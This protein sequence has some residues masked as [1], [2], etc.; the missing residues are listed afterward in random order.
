MN[1]KYK[2]NFT[3]IIINII[4]FICI[5]VA[6]PAQAATNPTLT[7]NNPTLDNILYPNSHTPQA[8]PNFKYL[9]QP[10][11]MLRDAATDGNSHPGLYMYPD[12]QWTDSEAQAN[13][14][15]GKN[16]F[17]VNTE[18][19]TNGNKTDFQYLI[20]SNGKNLQ[21]TNTY[22]AYVSTPLAFLEAV[23]DLQNPDYGNRVSHI[24]KVVIKQ[25]LDFYDTSNIDGSFGFANGSTFSYNYAR[26]FKFTIDGQGHTINFSS[27]CIALATPGG[28]YKEDWNLKNLHTYGSTFWGPVAGNSGVA[29]NAEEADKG[30]SDATI[31][32][33]GGFTRITYD[34]FSYLGAQVHNSGSGSSNTEIVIKNRVDMSS[35]DRYK[36][37][38]IEYQCD[39]NGNQQIFEASKIIFDKNSVFTGYTYDGI[40]IALNNAGLSDYHKSNSIKLE[41]GAKVY[42]FPHGDGSAET[43]GNSRGMPYAITSF[44]DKSKMDLYGDAELN[45]ISN[46]AP[47]KGQYYNGTNTLRHNLELAGGLYVSGQFELNYHK[48]STG[49]PTIRVQSNDQS[50]MDYVHPENNVMDQNGNLT[51]PATNNAAVGDSNVDW[52]AYGDD[53]DFS[54]DDYGKYVSC[55]STS[56]GSAGT[57]GSTTTTGATLNSNPIIYLGNSSKYQ[58]T[59]TI[60]NGTFDVQTNNLHNFGT[61]SPN[62]TWVPSNG[63]VMYIGGGMN[64]NI[65]KDGIFRLHNTGDKQTGNGMNL[66]QAAQGLDLN[67]SN[68]KEVTLDLGPNDNSASNIVYIE[69]GDSN[70]PG[71]DVNVNNSTFSAT[72]NASVVSGPSG[73]LGSDDKD[74]QL[75]NIPIQKMKIPFSYWAIPG[76]LFQDGTNAIFAKQA[77]QGLEE[78]NGGLDSMNGK[79]FHSINF[80]KLDSPVID[81]QTHEIV[82]HKNREVHLTGSVTH[83]DDDTS[84]DPDPP[85]IR[86]TLQR[87]DQTY[88]LGTATNAS[89]AYGIQK[90]TKK[91]LPVTPDILGVNDN[92]QQNGLIAANGE[93]KIVESAPLYLSPDKKEVQITPVNSTTQKYTTY[94]YDINLQK[95]LDDLP[96]DS[97]IGD[98]SSRDK[99]NVSAV[100]NF[101]QTPE[102]PINIVNLILKTDKNVTQYLTG[103]DVKVPISY[104]DGN[105]SA[106]ELTLDGTVNDAGKDHKITS[107]NLAMQHNADQSDSQTN[108]SISGI[109]N[110][111]D[112]ADTTHKI[113]FSGQDDLTPSNR[114][115]LLGNPDLTYEYQVLPYPKYSGISS[116]PISDSQPASTVKAGHQTLITKFTPVGH[117]DMRK[118]RLQL[119]TITNGGQTS[120]QSIKV[121]ASYPNSDPGADSSNKKIS[122]TITLPINSDNLY[123]LSGKD[124][125]F[126]G[127]M[128]PADTTFTIKQNVD[129]KGTSNQDYFQADSGILSAILPDGTTKQ[130]AKTPAVKDLITEPDIKLIAPNKL[131][132]SAFTKVNRK[133]VY[134]DAVDEYVQLLN[135]AD[136]DMNDVNVYAQYQGDKNIA[137]RLYYQTNS[138]TSMNLSNPALI[139]QGSLSQ[140]STKLL[141]INPKSGDSNGLFLDL[142]KND[143]SEGKYDGALTWS[144]V[145]SLN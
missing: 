68:P 45:I 109:T 23:Y 74:V 43:A 21:S 66:L 112:T 35:V 144:A 5:G 72:G 118:V 71:G 57:D 79:E 7:T 129:V 115:P 136:Y 40:G 128:I 38:G 84:F 41:D 94:K 117:H 83:Y 73:N 54:T 31:E 104:F 1:I 98:I 61:A 51:I 90:G 105:A 67:I 17:T 88:D 127:D 10:S 70:N 141:N 33:G 25:D 119:G 69:G 89:Q 120:D 3:V 121:T 143:L 91:V 19:Q 133:A 50:T 138:S 116:F 80:G 140:K 2:L 131:N 22:T 24:S 107:S 6:R 12:F 96:K 9:T 48:D 63:Y 85:M 49:S 32:T 122:Q 99:L 26:H 44:G 97:P 39:S 47:A 55:L 36:Y 92:Q 100:T 62:S 15:D 102:Q 132:F 13:A 78:L 87:N 37:K 77:N 75:S 58:S 123:E 29:D 124:F 64:V 34:N 111:V 46:N 14:N 76:N 18:G 142:T 101:Q 125:S 8:P 110:S 16:Y 42:L 86:L 52:Q 113:S 65:K 95:V 126:A 145:N 4:Y 134:P 11:P 81:N 56:N 135:N 130:L 82:P 137:N 60:D 20:D 106:Q 27:H 114:Y 108:W 93:G 103:D 28:L 59:A 53:Y 139:F 30:T